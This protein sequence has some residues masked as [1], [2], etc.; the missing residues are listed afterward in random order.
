M[1]IVYLVPFSFVC[2]G[3]RVVFEQAN[4]LQERGHQ[5]KIISLQGD[6]GWFPLKAEF[7]PVPCFEG[8]IPETDIL[9]ATFNTTARS[10]YES[11]RGI[12]FYLIQGYES[13]F[14]EDRAYWTQC[15]ESYR[16]PLAHLYVSNWLKDLIET[17]FGQK[18][19]LV[20]NGI[21]LKQ[22]KPSPPLS[23]SG[24]KKKM[25]LMVYSPFKLKNC[26]D[27]LL[28]FK[29]AREELAGIE[30][31][32]FG[33]SPSPAV[34][35]PYTYFYNPAQGNIPKIYSSSDC[36]IFP[37]LAEGF[38]LPPL[39]AMACG[40]PVV[41]TDCGGIRDFAVD[42]QSA[43]LVSPQKIEEMART[44]I[45]LL[46]D[47]SLRKELIKNGLLTAKK[48]SWDKV[49]TRLEKIFKEKS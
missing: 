32:M 14:Y 45:R 19:Y 31:I 27:G 49:V 33:T 38:G 6:R 40:C 44:I 16:L 41:T 43:L 3:L 34:D 15:E 37:S 5:V 36:L 17:R 13:L 26:L 9:I 23:V 28:S 18:G 22:F 30:L 4:R 39:E 25:I 29:L 21:D 24:P 7:V 12:P 2:G 35:F 11:G 42:S 46:T 10:A 1:K 20:S 47:E 8:H 48:F